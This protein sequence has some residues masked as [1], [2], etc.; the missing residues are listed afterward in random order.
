[1]RKLRA[2]AALTVAISLL[3]ST[4]VLAKPSPKSGD[5]KA[6][7]NEDTNSSTPQT[8]KWTAL[9]E[10]EATI[11]S[12]KPPTAEELSDLTVYITQNTALLGK[13]PNVKCVVK[14]NQPSG[15]KGG[16]VPVVFAV[17]GLK[18]GQ[19]DIYAYIRGAGGQLYIMPCVVFNGY[20]GYFAPAF[21]AVAIVELL[22]PSVK[23]KSA[24]K[25]LH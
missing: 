5:G 9:P 7:L 1:M 11:L 18:N 3:A 17:S 13:T 20:V 24:G 12:L 16:L 15:Y 2:L 19:A 4:A 23:T 25:K 6:Y 10:S 8:A 21:G 14:T 22:N